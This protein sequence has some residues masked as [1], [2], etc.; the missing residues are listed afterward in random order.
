MEIYIL[1]LARLPPVSPKASYARVKFWGPEDSW[2]HLDASM[3]FQTQVR[4]G[5]EVFGAR[6]S[7][8]FQATHRIPLFKSLCQLARPSRSRSPLLSDYGQVP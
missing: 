4:W 8:I 2:L 3:G 7:H 1:E 5:I 6:Y